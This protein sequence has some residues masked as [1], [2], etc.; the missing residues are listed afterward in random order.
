MS[1][2]E[3]MAVLLVFA[4]FIIARAGLRNLGAPESVAIGMFALILTVVPRRGSAQV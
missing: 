3:L 4:V 2:R 1:R